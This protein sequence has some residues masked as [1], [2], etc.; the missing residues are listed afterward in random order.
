MTVDPTALPDDGWE[1][2]MAQRAAQRRAERDDA[3]DRQ[4]AAEFER[5]RRA[6]VARFRERTTLADLAYS[7]RAEP[8]G[9]AC[10]GVP[11]CCINGGVVLDELQRGAHIVARLLADL[12]ERRAS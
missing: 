1:A 9:C 2:R 4:W 11:F 3:W 8:L 12:A 10:R 6:D 7:L 5:M